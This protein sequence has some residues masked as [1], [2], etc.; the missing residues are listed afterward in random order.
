MARN[1]YQRS[2]K[3]LDVE[4]EKSYDEVA[5]IHVFTWAI[6]GLLAAFIL[7]ARSLRWWPSL[8][9]ISTQGL[10]TF[11][12]IIAVAAVFFMRWNI[13]TSLGNYLWLKESGI[14]RRCENNQDYFQYNQ[15]KK[16]IVFANSEHR[17]KAVIVQSAEKSWWLLDYK[18]MDAM[19]GKIKNR[20]S[21]PVV[22]TEHPA[23][24]VQVFLAAVLV[25]GGLALCSIFVHPHTLK[26]V[27]L[28]V[29]A[30]VALSLFLILAKPLSRARSEN[31]RKW[32][33]T[34]GIAM[35]LVAQAA[36]FIMNILAQV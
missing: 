6:Y 22:V 25:L 14:E 21:Y 23:W 24:V 4:F 3:P 26:G 33:I 13:R 20:I 2:R 19:I 7:T 27:G 8:D 36:F 12:F 11:I 5:F 31:F 18:N 17:A 35:P 9:W 30:E 28:N 32:E 10:F 34:Y 15:I 29:A 1:Y 16:L